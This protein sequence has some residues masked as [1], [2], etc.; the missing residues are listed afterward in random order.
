M[1]FFFFLFFFFFLMIRRPPRSTLFPYTTL[2]QSS[3]L[4][5]FADSASPLHLRS[6]HRRNASRN[7]EGSCRAPRRRAR[8]ARLW[9]SFRRHA[10]LHAPGNRLR[11]SLRSVPASAG[12]DLR[13]HHAAP[14][15]RTGQARPQGRDS[16]SEFCEVVF[17]AEA[18]NA[19]EQP[20]ISG[21]TR[22][23]SRSA[24]L[25]KSSPRRPCGAA[26]RGAARRPSCF[27]GGFLMP[28][29]R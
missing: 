24:C 25:V 5:H 13:A 16:L 7:P 17:F 12:S 11:D 27:G 23:N 6:T 18:Q 20:A 10:V 21:A 26:S 1:S 28:A 2:F 19:G 14:S 4:H 22:R 8:H 15:R 3:L 29:G 9:L